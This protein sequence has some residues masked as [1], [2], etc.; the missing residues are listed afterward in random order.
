MK[1]PGI[2]AARD[3]LVASRYSLVAV[4]CSLTAV[5]FSQ[6]AVRYSLDSQGSGPFPSVVEVFVSKTYVH[7]IIQDT[8]KKTMFVEKINAM[9]ICGSLYLVY[10]VRHFLHSPPP[11]H[12]LT[13]LLSLHQLPPSPPSLDDSQMTH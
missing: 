1:M 9:W 3:L 7:K 11:Y 6:A 4:R 8:H 13:L 2:T 5:S 12:F 10:L